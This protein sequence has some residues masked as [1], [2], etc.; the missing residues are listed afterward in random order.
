MHGLATKPSNEKPDEGTT[1]EGADQAAESRADDKTDGAHEGAVKRANAGANGESDGRLVRT[2]QWALHRDLARRLLP[3]EKNR[4]R[5]Q[6]RV[7]RE[8]GMRRLRHATRFWRPGML[9]L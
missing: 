7:R 1:H 9:P 5:M 8:G 3:P 6:G 2:Y 4:R